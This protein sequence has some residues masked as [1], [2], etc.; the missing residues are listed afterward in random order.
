MVAAVNA[1]E[2]AV[3][4]LAAAYAN[5]CSAY[6]LAASAVYAAASAERAQQDVADLEHAVGPERVTAAIH[7]RLVALGTARVVEQS[8]GMVVVGPEWVAWLTNQ[9]Q[10]AVL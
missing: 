1:A 5:Y 6:R 9:I 7:G 4:N 3:V 10:H 2:A 8:G